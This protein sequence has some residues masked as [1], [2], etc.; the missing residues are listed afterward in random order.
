MFSMLDKFKAVCPNLSQIHSHVLLTESFQLVSLVSL[1]G[2]P[3]K[4]YSHF[5][6]WRGWE[7]SWWIS[8][9]WIGQSNGVNCVT[10]GAARAE[11]FRLLWMEVYLNDFANISGL[12]PYWLHLRLSFDDLIFPPPP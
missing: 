11:E 7:T 2:K 8:Q 9:D 1:L 4:R 12:V 10:I 3:F 6:V 5:G